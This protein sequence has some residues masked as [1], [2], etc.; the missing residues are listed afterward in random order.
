MTLSDYLGDEIVLMWVEHG[1]C[2]RCLG[3]HELSFARTPPKAVPGRNS[4]IPLGWKPQPG[5]HIMKSVRTGRG[6]LTT[7]GVE[8]GSS[9]TAP[10]SDKTYARI[11]C[12]CIPKDHVEK[13]AI[14]KLGSLPVTSPEWKWGR[15]IDLPVV[16]V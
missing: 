11:R 3:I 4:A 10:D 14:E 9:S 12:V 8:T 2:G 16:T 7:P 6:R 15:H 5:P 13:V 1:R